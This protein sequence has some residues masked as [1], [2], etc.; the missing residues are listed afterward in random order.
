M[1]EQPLFGNQPCE[2][3]PFP[4]TCPSCG[5]P[6]LQRN[7]P[8]R[9]YAEDSEYRRKIAVCCPNRSCRYRDERAV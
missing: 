6:L 2:G 1:A 7:V 3:T 4:E 5:G 9:V 8:V